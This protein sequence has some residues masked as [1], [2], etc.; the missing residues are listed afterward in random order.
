MKTKTCSVCKQEQPVLAF[1]LDRTSRKMHQRMSQCKLCRRQ[2]GM[3]FYYKNRSRRLEE[4]KR[5]RQT[6]K[7]KEVHKKAIMKHRFGITPDMRNIM[8]LNQQG[9]C[10][11]CGKEETDKHPDG[12]IKYLSIDHNHTTGKIRALLCGNCNKMLGHAK[13]DIDILLNAA[14]YLKKHNHKEAI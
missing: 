2:K 9:L 8:F 4:T 11:I 10:A 6:E 1:H 7:G 12:T 5:Y 13:E 3:D 14:E